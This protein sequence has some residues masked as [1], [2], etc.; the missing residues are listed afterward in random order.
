MTQEKKTVIK[1]VL[2]KIIHCLFNLKHFFNHVAFNAL[3]KNLVNNYFL[4]H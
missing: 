3:L 4:M 2:C 1:Y